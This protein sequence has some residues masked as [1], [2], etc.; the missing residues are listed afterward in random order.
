MSLGIAIIIIIIINCFYVILQKEEIEQYKNDAVHLFLILKK[1]NR[2]DKIRSKQKKDLLN[3]K[4]QEID[5]KHLQQENLL[6]ELFY[7]KKEISKCLQYKYD[8]D[9]WSYFF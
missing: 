7:L 2:L 9:N 1:L 8:F 3:K 5:S 4:K 6:N